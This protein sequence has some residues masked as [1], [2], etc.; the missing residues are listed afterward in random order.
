MAL[1]GGRSAQTKSAREVSELE[2]T[3]A[4]ID[5]SQA[6]IEF[7]L[8]GTII[9]ANENFLRTMGYSLSEVQG[10][11]H[12]LFVSP[13]YARSAE[14]KDFWRGLNSGQFMAGKFQRVGKGGA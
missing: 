4:A 3:V 10:R 6:M 5:R 1:F 13:E 14:Y 9:T 11:H 7:D 8:D 2:A 12:S